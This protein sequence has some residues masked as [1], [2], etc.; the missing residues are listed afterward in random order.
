MTINLTAADHDLASLRKLLLQL[1]VKFAYREGDFILSSGQQSSYYINGK[2]VTLRGEGALAI[3]RSILPLLTEDTQ[4]VA[5]LTLG[6]DPIVTAVS[7]VA[8]LEGRS[9]AA[10]IVRKEAKGHGTQ[11]YVEGPQL[12]AN[13]KVVVLEDVVTTGKS[14]MLAVERLRQAG[15]QVNEVIALVDRLQGGEEFYREQ[16]LKFQA[17]FAITD[18]QEFATIEE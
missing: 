5:G 4:A 18:I 12:P 17:L 1:F 13:A 3:G 15:Y 11:V 16:N 10:L 7:V 9:M 6:A 14:A 2:E 8:A